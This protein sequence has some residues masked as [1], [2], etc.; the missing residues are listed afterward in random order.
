MTKRDK[1]SMLA[2]CVGVSRPFSIENGSGTKVTAFANSKPLSCKATNKD[3]D[4]IT[5]DEALQYKVADRI[6][7]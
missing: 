1:V 6:T 5:K 3:T 4:N 2:F 7:H